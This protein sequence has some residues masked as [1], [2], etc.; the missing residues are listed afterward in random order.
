MIRLCSA[1]C[2][3]MALAFV[4]GCDR[5]PTLAEIEASER[6]ERGYANAMDDLQAGRMDAAIKGF[7]QVLKKNPTSYSAHFQLATLMQDVRKDYISAIVHYRSYLAM[8]PASDKAPVATDRVKYCETLLSAEIVR[9]AGGSASNKLATD[10]E[11]LVAQVKKL[12]DELAKA[13]KDIARLEQEKSAQHQTI[14]KLSSAVDSD[15]AGK[16]PHRVKNAVA[17]LKDDESAESVRRRLKP[18]DA[19]L[20]DDDDE[21]A[22]SPSV[23]PGDIKKLKQELAEL[24]AEDL[25]RT[26]TAKKAGANDKTKPTMTTKGTTPFDVL[27]GKK[28]A[29]EKGEALP[30]SYVVQEGET[31]SSIALKFYGNRNAWRTIQSA[32]IAIIPANGRVRQGQIIKLPPA[33]KK[34]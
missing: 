33:N 30:E 2:V 15:V 7:E 29:R 11:K 18:T 19:E 9:K 32:N 22:T 14:V 17:S 12:T 16:D 10:N 20:L 31:L 4:C 21:V 23:K 5:G 28:P 3:G 24:D 34:P 8:R 27:S 13:K 1:V 6:S 26:N 25:A